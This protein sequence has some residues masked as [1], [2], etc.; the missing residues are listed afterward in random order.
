MRNDDY[1]I[2]SE[3][4]EKARY[5]KDFWAPY[6]SDA[7]V[8]TLAAS[9]YTW[10]RKERELLAKEGREPLEFNIMRRPLQF[11]SGY[12]RD[13]LNSIVVTPVEGSD[14]KTADQ[15][16]ELQYYVWDKGQGYTTFL[17]AADEMFKSG[18]SLCGLQMDYSRDF[19]NGEIGFY[20][21]TYNSF[22]LDPTFEKLDL[23]D[24]AYAITRDL[25]SRDLAKQMLPFID[26]QVID[27]INGSFSDDKFLSYHPNFSNLNRNR[28]IIAYD[29]YYRR[30]SKS[31]QFLV[32][33]E[34]GYFRDIT[35]LESEELDRLKIGLNR[36]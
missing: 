18:M 30:I 26:P 29:Q 25:L 15:F 13:N 35:D 21:R 17:D 22:Y 20:K 11:F 23:S 19:I 1:D 33:E 27:D 32:D 4:A 31:R 3:F 10:S 5:C 28:N 16:T 36:I 12:L 7:Q 9:G 34:A 24:C 6:L 8:Y 2:K 14:E